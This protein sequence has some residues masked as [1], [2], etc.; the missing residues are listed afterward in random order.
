MRQW[1]ELVRNRRVARTTSAV[2]LDAVPGLFKRLSKAY[3]SIEGSALG[4]GGSGTLGGVLYALPRDRKGVQ[5][6]H[7]KKQKRISDLHQVT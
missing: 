2:G 6:Q 5:Q 3:S 4:G 7:R 1:L